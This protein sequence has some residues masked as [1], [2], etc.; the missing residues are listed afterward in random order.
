MHHKYLIID[1]TTVASG[2]YNFSDNAEHNT[3]E[4]VVL[5]DNSRYPELVTAFQANFTSIWSTGAELLESLIDTVNS[6]E[7]F[8]IVFD[9]M[10]LTWTQ[11]TELKNAIRA[12]CA[13]IYSDEFRN[14]ATSHL[15]CTRTAAE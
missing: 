14:N 6:E 10:A 2:S 8:P 4:N 15:T 13:E 9:S 11:V 1:G 5:Y 12:N 7:T 3:I